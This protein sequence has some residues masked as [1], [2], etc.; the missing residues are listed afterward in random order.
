MA[1]LVKN[2]LAAIADFILFFVLWLYLGIPWYYAFFLST[3]V[4]I[5]FWWV[6]AWAI[7]WSMYWARH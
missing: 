2:I 6:L 4:V 3:L 1:D 7:G 5:G